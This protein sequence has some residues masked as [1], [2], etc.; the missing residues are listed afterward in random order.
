MNLIEHILTPPPQKKIQPPENA[1]ELL[2]SL[3]HGIIFMGTF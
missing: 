2:Y 1:L 3:E